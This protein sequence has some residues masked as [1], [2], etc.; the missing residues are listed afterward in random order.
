MLHSTACPCNTKQHFLGCTV[1][2]RELGI[3]VICQHVDCTQKLCC[4]DNHLPRM[5]LLTA[6]EPEL[7]E[8]WLHAQTVEPVDS[9]VHSPLLKLSCKV[10]SISFTR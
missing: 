3:R 7:L 2:P 9:A 8:L 4:H 6:Y 5:M 1:A 10:Y